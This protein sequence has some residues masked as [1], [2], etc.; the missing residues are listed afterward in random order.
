MFIGG[1]SSNVTFAVDQDDIIQSA[2][3]CAVG[4]KSR[5]TFGS[6]IFVPIVPT[7]STTQIAILVSPL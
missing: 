6:A 5:S 4:L 7:R 2:V 1:N 3:D